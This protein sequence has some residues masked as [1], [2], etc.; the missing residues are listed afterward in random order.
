G[1][2]D[3]AQARLQSRTV[4]GDSLSGQTQTFRWES[5]QPGNQ[6]AGPAI[7]EGANTTYF[8]PDAWMATLDGLGNAVVRRSKKA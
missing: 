5:L 4:A 2:P 3:S 7:L 1:L 6:V 8:I